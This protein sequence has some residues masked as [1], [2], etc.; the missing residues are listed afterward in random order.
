MLGGFDGS[1]YVDTSLVLNTKEMKIRECDVVIPNIN[2][3]YQFL[4]Q[5]ESCF[6]EIEPGVQI[7]YDMKNNV[8]LITK[9]T[10]ELYSETQ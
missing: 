7:A 4:F 3:H 8:H 6:V 1:N 2:T 5:K 10:Y 9:N